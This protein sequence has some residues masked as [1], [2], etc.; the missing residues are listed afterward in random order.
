MIDPELKPK[1]QALQADELI[2]TARAIFDR[3]DS[4]SMSQAN[5]EAQAR[6]EQAE[7]NY[8]ALVGLIDFMME[9]YVEHSED[10]QTG[11]DMSSGAMAVVSVLSEAIDN[12]EMERHLDQ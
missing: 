5:A 11:V 9:H 12:A 1:L 2:D 8:P 6:S 4:L 3:L 10:P 7:T